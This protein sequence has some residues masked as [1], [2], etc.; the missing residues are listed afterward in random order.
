MTFVRMGELTWP[1]ALDVAREQAVGL[2][3]VG[4]L[5]QHGPHLPIAFDSICAEALAAAV[6]ERIMEPVVVPPLFMAGLSDHHLA[7]PGTVSLSPE[8]FGA[9]LTAY[10]E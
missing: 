2:I 7:F 6:A 5:E 9:V 8:A 4:S 3:P 1:K 10:V